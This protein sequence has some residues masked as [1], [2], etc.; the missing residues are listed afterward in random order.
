MRIVNSRML[1]A[2]AFAAAWLAAG[3]ARPAD[4]EVDRGEMCKVCTTSFAKGECYDYCDH[5]N[6]T[7]CAPVAAMPRQTEAAPAAATAEQPLAAPA[8]TAADPRSGCTYPPCPT[9]QSVRAGRTPIAMKTQQM[10]F[11]NKLMCATCRAICS[12]TPRPPKK[13]SATGAK[14]KKPAG[15]RAP[16]SPKK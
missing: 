12:D 14:V 4:P 3:G 2:A 9:S 11:E 5:S 16:A 8:G 1:G 13:A 7:Q 15:K 6:G 10:K